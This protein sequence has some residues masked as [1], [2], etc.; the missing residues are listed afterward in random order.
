M[1]KVTIEGLGETIAALGELKL[2]TQKGVLRRVGIDGLAPFLAELEANTVRLTGQLEESETIGT[3]LSRRQAQI[4][5][6][7]KDSEVEVYAGP[8]PLPQAIQEEFGNRHQAA[9][10]FVRPAW[11]AKEG[12]VRD[13]VA[14]GLGAE[15]EKTAQRVARRAAARAARIAAGR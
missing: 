12:E 15:V 3:H 8:G 1:A 2:S 5:A 4:Q 14:Q 11:D 13:R 6:H 9:R 7:E 10:P